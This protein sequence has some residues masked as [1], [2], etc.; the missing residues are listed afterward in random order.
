MRPVEELERDLG[1]LIER[2]GQLRN[3]D[4]AQV[5]PTSGKALALGT[6]LLTELRDWR[7]LLTQHMDIWGSGR[8]TV[9]AGPEGVGLQSSPIAKER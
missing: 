5:L 8:V 1:R 2:I 7:A 9:M 4:E 6:E 3:S